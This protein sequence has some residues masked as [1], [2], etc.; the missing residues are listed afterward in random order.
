M[1]ELSQI[2]E[3][4]RGYF[5]REND[6]DDM[7]KKEER[8]YY[9]EEKPKVDKMIEEFKN[10]IDPEGKFEKK[11]NRE[12]MEKLL[13]TIRAMKKC[14]LDTDKEEKRYK[15]LYNK[16]YKGKKFEKIDLS[17]KRNVPI[18]TINPNEMKNHPKGFIGL[19][20]FHKENTP[21]FYVFEDNS[22]HCFGCGA[23][24]QNAI[25]FIIKL[26]DCSAGEAIRIL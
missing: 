24:G 22:F 3:R 8:R 4:P 6:I 21:S 7:L 17:D 5:W 14:F 13:I 23:N 11:R 18:E 15:Y 2:G 1:R 19:C 26:K 12:E 20:P 25:D 9:K 16:L 10:E